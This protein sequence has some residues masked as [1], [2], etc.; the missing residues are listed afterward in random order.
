MSTLLAEG[1]EAYVDEM[2]VS[3]ANFQNY[4]QGLAPDATTD[5]Y[6]DAGYAKVD[7]ADSRITGY[8]SLHFYRSNASGGIWDDEYAG[9][10]GFGFTNKN[11]MTVGFG[12]KFDIMPTKS[13]PILAFRNDASSGYEEQASVWLTPQGRLFCSSADFQV[14]VDNQIDPVQIA[15]SATPP[16]G[17]R[18]GE[19]NYVE[20]FLDYSDATAP[21]VSFAVNGTTVL[22]AAEDTG[23]KKLDSDYLSA[24][25]FINPNNPYFGGAAF[26]QYLDDVYITG[27]QDG[28]L[29]PQKAVSLDAG[30]LLQNEWSGG[31]AL[32]TGKFDPALIASGV[33]AGNI[34]EVNIYAMDD[35]PVDIAQLNALS[36]MA[37]GFAGYSGGVEL[38]DK[39]SFGVHK[40]SGDT[41]ASGKTV[42]LRGDAYA[43]RHI[44]E[45]IP[46][47]SGLLQAD[48]NALVLYIDEEGF[49]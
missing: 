22:D 35:L 32:L 38:S 43:H 5:W 23:L 12:L 2:A 49:V 4:M 19:W 14:W 41:T 8:Q 10:F 39:I 6:A 17:F 9:T 25:Y 20:V 36:V 29:G 37:V 15:A 26:H 31:G 40:S 28:F 13:I 42:M 46:G 11:R 3:A 1:F 30:S 24:V 27:N 16:G 33:K 21:K 45:D 48:V 47:G 34:G 7:N 18:F 44:V